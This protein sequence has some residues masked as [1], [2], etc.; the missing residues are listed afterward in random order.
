MSIWNTPG[1]DKKEP[2]IP[3][4]SETEASTAVERYLADVLPEA[5]IGENK[6]L[7]ELRAFTSEES[8]TRHL[9]LWRSLDRSTGAKHTTFPEW[10]ADRKERLIQR[11]DAATEYLAV[12]KHVD[13]A[14]TQADRRPEEAMRLLEQEAEAIDRRVQELVLRGD[15]SD[16][17]DKLRRQ[18]KLLYS[19]INK[20]DSLV[21]K[22]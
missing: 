3:N 15:M 16:E 9:E 10:L 13:R 7:G 18:T 20:I 6:V 22:Q 2:G 8:R 19:A 14:F 1:F 4:G 12:T 17:A 21:R 5:S 11:L